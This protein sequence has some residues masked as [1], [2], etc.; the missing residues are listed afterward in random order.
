MGF[1]TKVF[2]FQF[3]TQPNISFSRFPNFWP[4]KGYFLVYFNRPSDKTISTHTIIC[5]HMCGCKILCVIMCGNFCA[6][7]WKCKIS[8]SFVYSNTCTCASS[9]K[10]VGCAWGCKR[11][12]SHTNT[13]TVAY[14]KLGMSKWSPP[15]FWRQKAE[16]FLVVFDRMVTL[17]DQN[18]DKTK[19]IKI[20]NASVTPDKC[21][22]NY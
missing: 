12:P 2:N 1:K 19:P 13:L 3:L 21:A 11:K 6:I 5:G 4:E 18:I 16:T 22:S 7:V 14:V 17:L 8:N 10:Y 15:Y 9:E 20:G